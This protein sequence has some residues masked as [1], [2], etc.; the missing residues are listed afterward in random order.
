MMP[1]QQQQQQ[2]QHFFGNVRIVLVDF[3]NHNKKHA[4]YCRHFD[5]YIDDSKPENALFC[6]L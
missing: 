2:Q 4:Y 6:D 1:F 5:I 3:K